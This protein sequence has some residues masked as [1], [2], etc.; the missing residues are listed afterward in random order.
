MNLTHIILITIYS[1]IAMGFANEGIKDITKDRQYE[2]D[3]NQRK[4]EI[5]ATIYLFITFPFYLSMRI[6]IKL[7]H[8]LK[9]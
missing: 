6:G 1:F 7:H 4:H 3:T 2:P 5:L 8:I 9:P